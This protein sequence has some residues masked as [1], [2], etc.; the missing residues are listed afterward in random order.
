MD[1]QQAALK[2]CQRLIEALNWRWN[3]IKTEAE[4]LS[5][6]HTSWDQRE[7]RIREAENQLHSAASILEMVLDQL[8]EDRQTL[9]EC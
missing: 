5:K 2:E 3:G 8:S 9:E 4:R 6:V 7:E 1:Q